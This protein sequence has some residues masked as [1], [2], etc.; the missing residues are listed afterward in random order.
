MADQDEFG[1]GDF[2]QE[3]ADA[4]GYECLVVLVQPLSN[5]SR[6]RRSQSNAVGHKESARVQIMQVVQIGP[7]RA[8]AR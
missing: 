6:S 1:V 4:Y 2:V 3:A 7:A 8:T 5:V